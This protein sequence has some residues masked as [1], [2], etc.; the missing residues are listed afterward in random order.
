MALNY[1][2][3]A[4]LIAILIL[5]LTNSET[6]S[7]AVN[8][9]N[10]KHAKANALKK[11]EL[12]MTEL[13]ALIAASKNLTLG[14]E[15]KDEAKTEPTTTKAPD[16]NAMQLKFDDGRMDVNSETRHRSISYEKTPKKQD[17]RIKILE[18]G[19]RQTFEQNKQPNWAIEYLTSTST[20][21]DSRTIGPTAQI[22]TKSTTL[23]SGQQFNKIFHGAIYGIIGISIIIFAISTI[24]LCR[25]RKKTEDEEYGEVDSIY[26]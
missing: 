2:C 11:Y 18:R 24:T 4:L 1:S 26:S 17:D 13:A 22:L 25:T 10:G 7:G 23:N 20:A 14:K 12:N 21:P 3:I 19:T 16:I 8:P 15:W 6:T 9:N 5:T